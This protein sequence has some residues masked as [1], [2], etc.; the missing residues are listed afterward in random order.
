M[1]RAFE[2]L[3]GGAHRPVNVCGLLVPQEYVKT[4]HI[5]ECLILFPFQ[6][7]VNLLSASIVVH[8]LRHYGIKTRAYKCF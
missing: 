3:P 5:Y 8:C 4:F 7:L 2:V 1:G 6:P